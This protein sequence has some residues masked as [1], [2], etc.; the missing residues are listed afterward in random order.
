MMLREQIASREKVAGSHDAAALEKQRLANEAKKKG[1]VPMTPEARAQKEAR[2]QKATAA[3][4]ADQ[5]NIASVEKAEAFLRGET[6]GITPEEAERMQRFYAQYQVADKEK[7]IRASLAREGGTPDRIA[8][9]I[10]QKK[11]DPEKKR[12]AR[13]ELNAARVAITD[14]VNAWKGLGPEAKQ[15]LVRYG[16]MAPSQLM[17]A[18]KS[19]KLSGPEQV[20]ASRVQRL[21]NDDIKKYAG[22][23][24]S[25]SEGGRQATAIGLPSGDFNPW[26]SPDVLSDYIR[27]VSK[28]YRLQKQSAEAAYE[29][30]WEGMQ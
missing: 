1:G 16:G 4:L 3:W 12:A 17:A 30:L 28:L 23:A 15:M 18:L 2:E 13:D 21:I 29:N 24:V 25:S 9:S 19:A 14:A 6:E 11:A 10:E 22:S 20:A 5:A 7:L 8:A 27:K 26:Q